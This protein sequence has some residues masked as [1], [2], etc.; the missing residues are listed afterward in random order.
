LSSV[1]NNVIDDVVTQSKADPAIGWYIVNTASNSENKVAETIKLEAAKKGISDYF[2]EIVIPA[3]DY[4]HVRRGKKIETKK[5][6]LP[7]YLIVKMKMSEASWGLVKRVAGVA[8]F[9]GAD[10]RPARVS[11]YE[12]QRILEQIKQGSEAKKIK[13]SFEMSEAVK[14]IDG[15][16]DT[17]TGVIEEIDNAKGRL[18][19]L[20]SIFGREAPVDL[21][22][23]QVEQV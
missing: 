4:S 11:D 13:P 16:F 17:F 12:V 20:V 9:L 19:V 7:G 8:K 23:S 6:M 5:K 18:R 10:N 1:D 2:L 15:P 3:E 22:F 14:I 21:E